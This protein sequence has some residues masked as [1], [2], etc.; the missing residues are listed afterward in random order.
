MS[1]D[2]RPTL[3]PM[4]RKLQLWMQLDKDD[5]RAVLSLPHQL[6]KLA[7]A[8]YIVRDREK[9]THSCLLLSGFA[10][11][12]KLTG[13]GARQ[14]M[15]IQ[16][17]G[18]VVDLQNS[19]L[20][21]SDHNVQAL[22]RIEVA[23]IPIEAVQNL[24]FTRPSVGRAMWYETLV[25]ASIFREWTLNVGRRDATQRTAHL[26]CEFALR[27]ELAGLGQQC[28][29]QLPMTQEQLADA[30]GLTPVHV[31]RTLKALE[32]DGLIERSQRWVKIGN[33][34]TLAAVG[35]FDSTYLHFEQERPI[36]VGA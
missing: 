20:R 8:Q 3:L 6:K 9:P 36:P 18:D 14:I 12:H 15:S 4:F 30:L 11:R 10:Y 25:D 1:H 33:W 29:Y 34:E 17:K 31:N 26:L 19:L 35:D 23:L 7:P 24:A 32:K 27:L 21:Q 28:D 22:T 5:E 2:P 13:D 16:M